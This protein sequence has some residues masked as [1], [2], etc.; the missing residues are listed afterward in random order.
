M[1]QSEGTSSP[2]LFDPNI[3]GRAS[4]KAIVFHQTNVACHATIGFQECMN[5]KRRSATSLALVDPG[6]ASFRLGQTCMLPSVL[7]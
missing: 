1:I 7:K 3:I 5:E 6:L 2:S 4:F